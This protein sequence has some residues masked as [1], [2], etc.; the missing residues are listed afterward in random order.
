MLPSLITASGGKRVSA[1]PWRLIRIPSPIARQRTPLAGA[2][3][4][5]RVKRV[6]LRLLGPVVDRGRGRIGLRVLRLPGRVV[7]LAESADAL[8]GGIDPDRR[9]L[10]GRVERASVRTMWWRG[11]WLGWTGRVGPVRHLEAE[12]VKLPRLGRGPATVDVRVGLPSPAADLVS[13]AVEALR[14]QWPLPASVSSI[15]TVDGVF[16]DAERVNPR[17]RR[18][19]ADQAWARRFRLAVGSRWGTPTLQA[20]RHGR[21]AELGWPAVAAM[22]TVGVLDASGLPGRDPFAEARLLVTFAMTGV[23][24]H[25]PDLPPAVADLVA[26]PLRAIL[27]EPLPIPTPITDPAVTA[28]PS[29]LEL[30]VRSVRQRRTTLQQHSTRFGPRVDLPAVSVLL[31]TRRPEHLSRILPAIAGQSYPNL[32]IV[33]CLHGIDLPESAKHLL[34]ASGRR[35]EVVRVEATEPFGVALGL[36]TSR[37]SGEL[38]TKVDDDDTYGPDH[39]WDLVLARHYAAATMVGKGAEFIYLEDADVTVRRWSGRP[40][41][42]DSVVAGGTMLIARADLE[43]LGGWRPVPRSVDRGLVDRL[44]RAGATIYRTHPM[45]YLY[46]RRGTGHTWD[47]GTDFFLRNIRGRWDGLLALPEFGTG[48]GGGSSA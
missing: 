4:K 9:A 32:E 35:Y 40:E 27:A 13:A 29:T 10:R 17:G 47:P 28:Q 21:G 18:F 16:V 23:V 8:R 22:R 31:A 34:D 44:N 26:A 11:P 2:G 37:C 15:S 43:A 25:A 12:R 14:P 19:D 46:H 41:W 42:D 36:A 33:L 24:V 3:I 38:L 20:W 6:V 39:V 45:G 5:A 7:V 1:D 30:E 48:P